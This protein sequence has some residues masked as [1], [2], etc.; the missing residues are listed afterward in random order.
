MEGAG[1]RVLSGGRDAALGGS[2][3]LRERELPDTDAGES[4]RRFLS[5]PGPWEP[6]CLPRA[7]LLRSARSRCSGCW[8]NQGLSKASG[9][10]VRSHRR[11]PFRVPATVGHGWGGAH[12]VRKAPG[13]TAT[14]APSSP[15]PPCSVPHC[16]HGYLPGT[17]STQPR[18]LGICSPSTLPTSSLL[19]LPLSGTFQSHG[20]LGPLCGC[21]SPRHWLLLRRPESYGVLMSSSI[22][23]QLPTSLTPSLKKA[24]LRSHRLT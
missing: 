4:H 22:L 20:C 13:R 23:A 8:G 1:Q 7:S 24:P 5:L 14:T 11:C 21:P 19:S 3:A 9:D 15:W 16:C 2:G 12:E 17:L 10:V 18:V 6:V